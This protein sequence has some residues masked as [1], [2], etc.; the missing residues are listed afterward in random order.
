MANTIE[1]RSPY[2]GSLIGEILA[3]G[4]KRLRFALAMCQVK[5]MH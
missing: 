3:G 4:L 5:K 2:D 1:V